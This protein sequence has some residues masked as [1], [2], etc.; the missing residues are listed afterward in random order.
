MATQWRVIRVF[1]SSTFRDMKAERD[2]LVKF[3]F[4]EFRRMCERRGVV[5]GEVDLRWGV[6][7]EQKAE[8][9][10]LPVCLDE[11]H[12]C[13]PYFVGLL[14]ERYGWVPHEIPPELIER[15]P[16]LGEH[17]SS[18]VTELEILHGVLRNPEMAEHAFFYF[19]DPAYVERIPAERRQ[20]FVSENAEAAR[21][22][23]ELK[24]RIR[25]SGL[26]VRENYVDP[27]ALGELVRRD[28]AGVIDRLFP[29]GS[30][31]DPLDREAVGHEAYARSRQQVYIG[32]REYMERLDAYVASRDDRPLAVVGEPGGGKSALLAN[33]AL[34]YREA[35]PEILVLQHY[36]GASPYSADWMAMVRRII[37]ELKRRLRIERDIP[38]TPELLRSA[39]SNWL[40]M[41]SAQV[42]KASGPRAVV[43]IL[44]A[45]NQLEDRDGAPDLTWLPPAMPENVR[46]VVSTLPGRPLDEVRKRGWPTLEVRPLEMAERQ[47][48][49]REYLGQY[50]KTLDT[51]N[52]KRIAG[53]P[54]SANPLYLRVLLDELRLF[55]EHERLEERIGYYLQAQSPRELYGKVIARWEE[56]YV[57]GARLVG[58][59][60][61]L[62][63]AARRGLSESEL[64][65]V[66][67]TN[68]EPLPRA[69]WSPLYLAMGDGLVSQ[70]GLLTFAHDFLRAA[71]RDKCLPSEEESQTAHERL[72][73][74]FERQEPGPRRTDE[75][76]WQLA[77]A[78]AWQRLCDLLTDRGFLRE[79]WV[80]NEFDVK[81]FW[82][83]L[84]AASPLRM[85]GGL[86]S[87]DR[88]ARGRRGQVSS[89]SARVSAV[90]GWAPRGG[91]PDTGCAGGALQGCRRP[92][93]SGHMPRQPGKHARKPGRPRRGDG[94]IQGAGGHLPAAAR[95]GWP[96]P[97]PWQ[98]GEHPLR[99]RQSVPAG[100]AGAVLD[101]G[102]HL[103]GAGQ[104]GRPADLPR[105]PGEHPA[106][107]GRPG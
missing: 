20:D 22:L 73:D 34:R 8:G 45:L 89:A 70:S 6:T 106:H 75:L 63:W 88:A 97:R 1:V 95:P 98:P 2:Q 67:G 41:A 54:G 77:E 25:Q 76:P 16:W 103:P 5:W 74:Y 86:R 52:V 82:T 105:H 94:P 60:L 62:L 21:R 31:P 51:L 99:T 7:D 68:G 66:L 32:R 84:E 50:A 55:G 13:R 65:E 18:S 24:D 43:L 80:R 19:R 15:E 64:L 49:I 102:T 83:R 10:V 37:G 59:T 91:A 61:S 14:G 33:W 23:C 46:L 39:F 87:S 57:A 56:D 30:Q 4:P 17:L 26:P 42:G 44:D 85:V 101:G 36:I 12:R 104:P 38:E 81:A 48:L 35:H 79:L 107:T 3:V 11:I 92:R 69:A 9:K 71:V 93:Q 47:E 40:Y 53:A 29:E 58:D 78:Q 72:A 100:G 96:G 28:L 90:W 27:E